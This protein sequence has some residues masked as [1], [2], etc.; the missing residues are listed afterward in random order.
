MIIFKVSEIQKKV[1]NVLLDKY[2]SSKTYR[3]KNIRNQSFSIEPERVFPEYDDDYTDQDEVDEFNRDMRI[4]QEKKLIELQIKKGTSVILSIAINMEMLQSIYELLDRKDITIVRNEQ[5]GMYKEYKG[6]HQIIDK[7]CDVQIDRLNNFKDAE[8]DIEVAMNILR[9]LKFILTNK[10]DI[11]ERELSVAVLGDTK[12]FKDNYRTRICK[13]IEKYGLLVVNIRGLDE[14]EKKK[15]ILEEYHIFSNPSYVFFKGYV[16]IKYVDGSIITAKP[17]NPIAI[18]SEAINQ[19]D[20]VKVDAEKIV[21]VEN[22]TSYNR[23]NKMKSVFI[24]LS[25]Y[26]NTAKQNFLIKISE[27]NKAVNWYHFG[28]I[29]PDG[30][31]ILKNLIEKTKIA[32]QPINMGIEQLKKYS[33]YCKKFE[34]NDIIK[35]SS[36]VDNGF[37]EEVMQYM[38]DNNCKLEQEIIS[39]MEKNEL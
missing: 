26:H 15:V 32:F 33:R 34:K 37:Y 25:G 20:E 1:L 38:M 12:M 21:T 3:G 6:I 18:S 28:D 13:I 5:I 19:I 30:Y 35:A 24:Y 27:C 39:W 36:L 16:T 14:N 23:I 11:M 4:L 2:E 17:D 8:Y 7:F 29:D 31:Y 10:Q 9:L 22:L